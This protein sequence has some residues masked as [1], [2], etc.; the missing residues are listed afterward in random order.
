MTVSR[1]ASTQDLNDPN[2]N[3]IIDTNEA[4]VISTTLTLTVGLVHVIFFI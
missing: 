3:E 4:I 1:Y 2:G